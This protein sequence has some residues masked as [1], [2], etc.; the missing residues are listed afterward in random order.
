MPETAAPTESKGPVTITLRKPITFG[1]RTIDQITIRPLKGKDMR[2]YNDAQGDVGK[3]LLFASI[4]SGEMPGMIDELEGE[5]L[6]AVMDA[7]NAFFLAIQP[8]GKT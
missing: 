6:G 1:S 2:R 4:L 7:V 8:T 3:S 5:D